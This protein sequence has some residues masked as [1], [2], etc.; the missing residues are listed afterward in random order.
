[1]ETSHFQLFNA[2]GGFDHFGQ[3]VMERN[4]FVLRGESECD[5]NTFQS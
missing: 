4:A 3:K 5:T 1:M 2:V